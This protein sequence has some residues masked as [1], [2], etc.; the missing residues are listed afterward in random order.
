MNLYARVTADGYLLYAAAADEY[1]GFDSYWPD[2]YSDDF[3]DGEVVWEYV[4]PSTRVTTQV[5]MK[6]LPSKAL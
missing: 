1:T 4:N 2:Y 6:G 3:G 5:G